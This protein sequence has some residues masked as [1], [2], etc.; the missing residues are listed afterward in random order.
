M[1]NSNIYPKK[2]KLT[3]RTP[4]A[5]ALSLQPNCFYVPGGEYLIWGEIRSSA[6]VS[7]I[8]LAELLAKIRVMEGDPFSLQVLQ[9]QEHLYSARPIIES[10]NRNIVMSYR[11]GMRSSIQWNIFAFLSNVLIAQDVPWVNLLAPLIFL[12]YI[13]WT[14]RGVGS[15]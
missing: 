12:R 2:A 8:P 6:I 13:S 4:Q 9:E 7:V 14:Q 3:G 11:L 15:T 1:L 10:N 5:K